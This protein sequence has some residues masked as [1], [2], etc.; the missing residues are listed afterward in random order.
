[1]A[2]YI[3]SHT[4]TQIDNGV[5]KALNPDSV[6]QAGSS[7]LI[8]SDAVSKVQQGFAPIETSSTSAHAYA[9]DDLLVYNGV[10]YKAKTAIS[11]GNTPLR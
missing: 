7:S 10:L 1:M 11:V 5:D 4:G 6:P 3:S 9:V 2:K 8:T